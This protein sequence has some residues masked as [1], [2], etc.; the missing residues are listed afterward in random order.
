MVPDRIAARHYELVR[1]RK[2]AQER[3]THRL[4]AIPL[5]RTQP[6]RRTRHE[7][8][9][10][11]EKRKVAQRCS[12]KIP[13]ARHLA[14]SLSS[15]AQLVALR[16]RHAVVGASPRSLSAGLLNVSAPFPPTMF[17]PIRYSRLRPANAALPWRPLR[18]AHALSLLLLLSLL[19]S[20]T[21]TVWLRFP[22]TTPLPLLR[23]LASHSGEGRS[24]YTRPAYCDQ[25]RTDSVSP[26]PLSP[27]NSS[28]YRPSITGTQLLDG[29]YQ[30]HRS[31]YIHQSW[32]TSN[33]PERFREWSSSWQ[34][35]NPSLQLVIWNDEEN[36]RLVREYY[37]DYNELYIGFGAG[38][39]RADFARNLYMHQFVPLVL[40]RSSSTD[41]VATRYGG[42]Y[43]DLD[44]IAMK[45]I[46]Q[47]LEF[48]SDTLAHSDSTL[49][50]PPFHK[51]A[52][53]ARMG[54]RLDS[55]HSLPNAFFASSSPQHPFWLLPLAYANSTAYSSSIKHAEF[56][57]PEFQTGPVAVF[58]SEKLWRQQER[59]EA[60]LVIIDSVS[61]LR[62]TFQSFAIISPSSVLVD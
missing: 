57:S 32:K 54:H 61:L 43:V 40:P 37:P 45:P 13:T 52:Y 51:T 50:L 42:I 44:V 2:R 35:W 60:R 24:Y 23:Q 14:F 29:L 56:A 9:A 48:A 41:A 18:T 21:L 47:I 53:L 59:D 34:K 62:I 5:I 58:E 11:K 16:S 3:C 46:A 22:F 10:K 7:E 27:S 12:T 33:I 19:A 30:D 15:S 20:S 36:A 6:H 25:Y 28:S 31:H 8:T 4:D 17:M 55:V 26:L 39:R 38:I 1:K 49:K